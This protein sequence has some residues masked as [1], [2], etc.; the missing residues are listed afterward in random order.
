MAK[1]LEKKDNNKSHTHRLR[2]SV[3]TQ[4]YMLCASE[5]MKT[6]I[7]IKN[8]KW[9]YVQYIQ[10]CYL[11]R[12]ETFCSIKSTN[13]QIFFER[14]KKKSWGKNG[15]KSLPDSI[16]YCITTSLTKSV[17]FTHREARD[18]SSKTIVLS[19]RLLST[20]ASCGDG[21]KQ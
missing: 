15:K 19:G 10:K 16:S 11:L 1:H 3:Y 21:L 2:L 18:L 14:P 5:R 9:I 12:S 7:R 4:I 8:P 6:K 13:S 20:G 17:F